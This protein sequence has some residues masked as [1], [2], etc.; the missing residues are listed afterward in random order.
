MSTLVAR[1]Y[2]E[3]AGERQRKG[4]RERKGRK[5]EE[6]VEITQARL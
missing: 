6:K 5:K 1:S 2:R 4:K 3:D